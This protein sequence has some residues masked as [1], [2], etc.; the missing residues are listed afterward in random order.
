VRQPVLLAGAGIG[1]LAAAVACAQRGLPVQLLERAAQLSEVGAGIQIGPNVTRILQAWGLGAALAE[2]AAFPGKLQARDAQTGQVLGTLAVARGQ[3]TDA[4]QI[5]WLGRCA[6]AGRT[7]QRLIDDVLDL[8]KLKAERIPLDRAEF[9]LDLVLQAVQ[10]K[11]GPSAASKSIGLVLDVPSELTQPPLI[12]DS[13]RLSQVLYNL[14]SN[15]IKFTPQGSV[16]VRVT[17]AE[18]S[19]FARLLRFDIVDTGIG[20]SADDCKRLFQDFEQLDSTPTRAFAGC[21]IGLALS[22][23]L[24]QMMGGAIGVN[25]TPGRG[26]NFWFTV[27]LGKP[28]ALAPAQG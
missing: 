15:A 3:S 11:V 12:G 22:K 20:I 4:E 25:S 10:D 18:E 5:K 26:S 14:T 9:T 7:L 19:A 16:T 24:V 23:Y 13:A 6:D 1:G 27:R 28:H 21:G 2:V 17:Q 8:T